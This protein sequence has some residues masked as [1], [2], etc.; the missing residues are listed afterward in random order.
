MENSN[1]TQIA[2]MRE[3]VDLLR[4][5]Q[6]RGDITLTSETYSNLVYAI[7]QLVETFSYSL[8]N[9]VALNDRI[10]DLEEQLGVWG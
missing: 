10:A 9:I 3:W 8:D 7:E 5:C 4:T 1:T 6:R 2:A